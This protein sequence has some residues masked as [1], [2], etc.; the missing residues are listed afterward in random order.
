MIG[1]DRVGWRLAGAAVPSTVM[2]AHHLALLLACIPASAAADSVLPPTP[3]ECPDGASA[4]PTHCL[5]VCVP[6][7]C[8]DDEDC[9]SGQRC[10]D[11]PL[12]IEQVRC[13]SWGGGERIVSAACPT[14]ACA[15][16]TCQSVRSCGAGADPPADAGASGVHT[17]YG[18]GCRAAGAHRSPLLGGLVILLVGF[19]S[20]ASRI[21]R[22]RVARR[23]VR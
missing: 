13:G 16:G 17:A 15:E 12:C 20:R 14:G 21:D 2:R 9:P 18:C 1:S 11:H 5:T 8:D 7:P 3:L 19:V 6:R 22:R 23:A 10:A 4:T